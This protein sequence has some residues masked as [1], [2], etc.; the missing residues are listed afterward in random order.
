MPKAGVE[1]GAPNAGVD[2]GVPKAGVEEPAP[3][4]GVDD[5]VPNA[6]VEDGMPPKAGVDDGVPKAEADPN[7]FESQ[8]TAGGQGKRGTRT[9]GGVYRLGFQEGRHRTHRFLRVQ[10]SRSIRPFQIISDSQ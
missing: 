2:D 7:I 6:G 9:F 4:A 8:A 10:S 3:K 1:D 5:G